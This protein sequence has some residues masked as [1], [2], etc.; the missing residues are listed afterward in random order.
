ML[1]LDAVNVEQA[2]RAADRPL[3][4]IVPRRSDIESVTIPARRYGS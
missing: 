2:L 4:E 3:I 1:L